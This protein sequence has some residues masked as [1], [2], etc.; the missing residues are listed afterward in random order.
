MHSALNRL[1]DFVEAIT[2]HDEATTRVHRTPS[3]V[4]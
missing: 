1:P 3:K 2:K 4:N